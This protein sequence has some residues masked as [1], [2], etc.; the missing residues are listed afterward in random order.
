MAEEGEGIRGKVLVRPR[1][2]VDD[3]GAETQE[4]GSEVTQAQRPVRNCP[5]NFWYQYEET[6]QKDSS[7]YLESFIPPKVTTVTCENE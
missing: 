5:F 2:L 6:G 7:A 3:N 1:R 4:H